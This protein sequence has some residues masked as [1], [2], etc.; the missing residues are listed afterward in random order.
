MLAGWAAAVT[1]WKRSIAAGC[2]RLWRCERRKS[3]GRKLESWMIEADARKCAKTIDA[4]QDARSEA[5]GERR[6]AKHATCGETSTCCK[7][8]KKSSYTQWMRDSGS[9]DGQKLAGE[10]MDS[11]ISDG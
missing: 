6:R 4:V 8:G 3:D 10:A 5:D 1:R 9:G 11:E 2:Q 7:E